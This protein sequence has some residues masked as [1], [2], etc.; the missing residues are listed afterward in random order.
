MVGAASVEFFHG[1]ILYVNID[2][3][4]ASIAIGAN[5]QHHIMCR[6]FG[7]ILNL[8]GNLSGQ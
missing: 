2:I 8:F 5:G 6:I 1:R 4:D 7:R 3:N